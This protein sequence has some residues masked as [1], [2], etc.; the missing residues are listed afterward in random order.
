MFCTY[1][2][3][4]GLQLFHV[5]DH[6]VL[7]FISLV[8]LLILTLGQM[9]SFMLNFEALILQNHELNVTVRIT[10]TVAF[11][12]EVHLLQLSWCARWLNA[13][14]G[15]LWFAKMPTLCMSLPLYAAAAWRKHKM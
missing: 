6:D 8:M 4:I 2:P 10:T 9:L 1:D 15:G 3:N 14:E 11:L 5:K 12:L 7:P 13:Y